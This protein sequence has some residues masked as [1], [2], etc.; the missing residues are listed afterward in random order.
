MKIITGKMTGQESVR[1]EHSR[2]MGALNVP[3]NVPLLSELG[4]GP[5]SSARGPG[6][7]VQNTASFC[8]VFQDIQPALEVSE[9][10]LNPS[11]VG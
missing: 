1:C 4:E 10:P 6:V 3:S 11:E 9:R 8:S 2:L 7:D 5:L